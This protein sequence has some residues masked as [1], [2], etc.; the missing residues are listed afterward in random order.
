MD[1]TARSSDG[2]LIVECDYRY[3]HHCCGVGDFYGM[4]SKRD[5]LKS[6]SGGMLSYAGKHRATKDRLQ[7][8]WKDLTK[9]ILEAMDDHNHGIIT[10]SDA[11]VGWESI[12]NGADYD[13]A[14]N[15]KAYAEFMGF[16]PSSTARNPNSG[17]TISVWTVAEEEL[18]KALKEKF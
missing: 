10:F 5:I 12:G 16:E 15:N 8:L 9:E 4:K 18:E 7:S 1:I 3:S 2:K 14:I 13:D 17:H 11:V 6:S